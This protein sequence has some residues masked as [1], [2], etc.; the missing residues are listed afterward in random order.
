MEPAR[1]GS[2]PGR[3]LPPGRLA[4][5]AC[6]YHNPQAALGAGGRVADVS[7]MTTLL[8]GMGTAV[9]A[10]GE[11]LKSRNV[12][13]MQQVASLGLAAVLCGSGTFAI[14]SALVTRAALRDVSAAN[15]LNAV[16]Q[17]ALYEIGQE[18]SLEQKYRL[19]PGPGLRTEHDAAAR[20]LENTIRVAGGKGGVQDRSLAAALLEEHQAYVAASLSM[21]AAVDAKRPAQTLALD[22]ETDLMFGLLEAK[23]LARALQQRA[24]TDVI[25]AMLNAFQRYVMEIAAAL[26]LF[27][28]GC[29]I[30]YLGVVRS[31]KRRLTEAHENQIKALE[32]AI[33]IDH[34][35]NVGN[36]R[37][38][39]ENLA[40]ETSRAARQDEALSLALIDIDDMKVVN[41]ENGHMYGDS[42]LAALGS[43]LRQLQTANQPFRLGGDEFALLLPHTSEAETLLLMERLRETAKAS[44]SG[45]TISVGV[46]SLKGAACEP[47]ALQ[48]QA[49]AALYAAKRAG[50]NSVVA[51]DEKSDGMWLL[52][53]VK[54]QQLRRLIADEAVSI[55]FQPIWDVEGCNVLAYE[56]LSRPPAE[57]GFAGPQDVFDLAE[58]VGRAREIDA[59][60]RRAILKRANELPKDVLLF[61][62]V[63]PQSLDRGRLNVTQFVKE[64]LAAGL[65]PQR[66]VIEITERSVAQLEVVIRASRELQRAGFRLA[67][68]DTGAGNAGLEMLSQVPVDFVKID[69]AIIVKALTNRSA[70]GV[71]AGII[72][73]AR[74]TDAYVIAEGIED[75][76][77]LD[78]VCGLAF[79]PT[80][81]R[82]GVQGVQGFLFQRPSERIPAQRDVSGVR[83]LLRDVCL[84][85]P[86]TKKAAEAAPVALPKGRSKP[87]LHLRIDRNGKSS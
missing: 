30:A 66:I 6:A 54:V 86:K 32:E 16:Y 33:M 21:F 71:V 5:E 51:F 68:D 4:F 41:D 63:S 61:I 12:E 8:R 40:R 47:E 70:R 7:K 46:A 25:V 23:L 49:D 10:L 73:I 45:A 75:I 82:F 80:E 1:P 60:C 37:A 2:S 55:V 67:L 69:R 22:H 18:R 78:L 85:H 64:V 17:T 81:R 65:T 79:D 48:G 35:T 59:V 15:G 44:L 39:Q 34:L 29:I 20:S 24:Q 9:S 3:H 27:D 42:V 52:S 38:Y 62:N 76:E 19:E 50:R 36:H 28:L 11:R 84:R 58:R 74:E 14:G 87:H 26:S 53:P 72:A 43:M 31:Y 13:L 77:M 57:Y 56:A 83:E